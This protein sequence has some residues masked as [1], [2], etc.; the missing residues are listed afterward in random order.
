MM[1]APGGEM[2]AFYRH[3]VALETIARFMHIAHAP[4]V[5][6]IRALVARIVPAGEAAPV[7]PRAGFSGP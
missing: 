1:G 7:L 4:K 3:R 2:S 5:C 6:T